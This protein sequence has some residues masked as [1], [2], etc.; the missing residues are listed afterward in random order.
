GLSSAMTL[1]RSKRHV[2]VIDDNNP[3]N[4]QTPHLH[5]LITHDGEPPAVIRQ[6]ALDQVKR[7]DTVSFYTG[8]AMAVSNHKTF[9]EVSTSQGDVFSS[10]K[11]IF[12][13]GMKDIMP[14]IKGFAECWGISVLHCP[15]CHGYEVKDTP[16]GVI[17]N[18]K[19]AYE[20]CRMIHHWSK[21]VKLFTNGRSSLA[22]EQAASLK[23]H[24][25]EIVEEEITELQHENGQL[26]ELIIK[27]GKAYR[28][29]AAFAKAP[30][31]QHCT[32]PEQLGCE[33]NEQ[34]LLKVDDFQ[35][36][37]I[38]GIFAA[39]DN[40]TMF[41]SVGAAIASGIK[42]GAMANHQLIEEEF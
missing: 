5:N 20:Y 11:I 19:M 37:N 40:S 12:T 13:T 8:T 14:S 18:E 26:K 7:Y 25:I 22:P 27:S 16:L 38:H 23:M 3:C 9:F 29:T 33:L 10:K 34:G 39:G 15:Y 30:L 28:L 17:A 24:G 32:I 31:S 1:G 36:T 6:K 21:D 2:L 4:R 35:H 41:R 42:A